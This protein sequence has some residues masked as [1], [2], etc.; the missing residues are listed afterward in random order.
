MGGE[1]GQGIYH[2]P[3]VILAQAHRGAGSAPFHGY[4]LLTG[5]LSSR[6]LSSGQAALVTQ[7]CPLALSGRLRSAVAKLWALQ[8]VLLAPTTPPT[9][10]LCWVTPWESALM[11][12]SDTDRVSHLVCT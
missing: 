2:A 7:V 11:K 1:T 3:G 6:P 10:K 4:N 5:S 9:P 8:E 12:V